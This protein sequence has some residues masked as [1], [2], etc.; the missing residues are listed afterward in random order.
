MAYYSILLEDIQTQTKV[1][2]WLAERNGALFF[3]DTTSINQGME[4]IYICC[5]GTNDCEPSLFVSE[6]KLF[7]TCGEKP[8]C[9]NPEKSCKISKTVLLD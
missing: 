7:W 4:Q 1:C 2:R 3:D 8:S 9:S 6:G 5:T